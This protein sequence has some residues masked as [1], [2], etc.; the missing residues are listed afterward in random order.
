M[1]A[2]RALGIGLDAAAHD[3]LDRLQ[4]AP[5]SQAQRLGVPGARVAQAQLA[6][7]RRE[8]PA[9]RERHGDDDELQRAGDATGGLRAERAGCGDVGAVGEQEPFEGGLDGVVG[10]G[11]EDVGGGAPDELVGRRAEQAD[12]ADAALGDRAVGRAEHVAAVGEAEQHLLDLA[13][14][15]DGR[16]QLIAQK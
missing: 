2:R 6:E 15:D 3:A 4:R 13:V 7:Q 11:D 1:P 9:E 12:H 10:A 14:D 5:V 8:L 16:G